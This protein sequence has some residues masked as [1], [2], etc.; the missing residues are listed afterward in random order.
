VS[1]SNATV[2]N[3]PNRLQV[4]PH[5]LCGHLL[6]HTAV[7]TALARERAAKRKLNRQRLHAALAQHN[8]MRCTPIGEGLLAG[9]T[10]ARVA[11]AEGYASGTCACAS[12]GGCDVS[13]T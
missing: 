12:A 13:M 5:A 9:H 3:A 2:M 1:H 8:I 11:N 10:P 4:V 6:I 7:S